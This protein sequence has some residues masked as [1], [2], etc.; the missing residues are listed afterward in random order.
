MRSRTCTDGSVAATPKKVG[1]TKDMRVYGMVVF[2]VALP[3]QVGI[4]TSALPT[5]VGTFSARTL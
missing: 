1:Q 5:H 3:T 2:T 4:G